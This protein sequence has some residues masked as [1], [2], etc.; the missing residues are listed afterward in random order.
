MAIINPRQ[1]LVGAFIPN[2]IMEYRYLSQSAKMMWARMAQYAGKDGRCFPS[3]ERLG[4]DIGLSRSA[5]RKAMAELQKKGFILA[6]HATGKARLMHMTSE[7]FFLDHPVFHDGEKVLSGESEIGPSL[8]GPKMDNG[9][10]ENGPSLDSP[11]MDR[12]IEENHLRE[13]EENISLSEQSSD[14]GCCFSSGKTGRPKKYHGNAEDY[15]L[16]RRMFEA[17]T[18]V[19]ATVKEPS[20]DHWANSIRLMREQDHR[21][22]EEIWRVF[23]FANSDQFWGSNILSPDSLRRHFAKLA[24]RAGLVVSRVRGIGADVDE[25]TASGRV[26]ADCEFAGKGKSICGGSDADPLHKACTLFRMKEAV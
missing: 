4:H 15:S 17:I 22:H 5:A 6:K 11:K 25:G 9:Q 20:W 10:P 23:R 26:C 2:A 12:P 13:S 3:I 8:E 1:R 24:P 21:K 7:Y 19:N 14:D 18:V 16:A